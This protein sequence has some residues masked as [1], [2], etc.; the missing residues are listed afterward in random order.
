[1]QRILWNALFGADPWLGRAPDA[2]SASRAADEAAAIAAAQA[3]PDQSSIRLSVHSRD[4][5]ATETLIR[6]YTTAYTVAKATGK[7]TFLI[8]N[9][10]GLSADEHPFVGLLSQNLVDAGIAPVALR[11]P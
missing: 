4:A 2:G 6:R 8:A 5:A 9:P 3:L 10:N 1:M 7:V 11:V